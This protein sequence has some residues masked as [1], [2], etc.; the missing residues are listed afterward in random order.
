M[1]LISFYTQDNIA[2]KHN[3]YPSL[4]DISPLHLNIKYIP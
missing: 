2:S 1:A 4:L 3:L